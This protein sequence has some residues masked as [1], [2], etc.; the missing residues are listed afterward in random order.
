MGR[1]QTVSD[2]EIIS[3]TSVAIAHHG[4]GRL[5]LADVAAVA[6][7]SPAALVQ[8]FGSKHQLLVAVAREA[9]VGVDAAFAGAV[10][11]PGART[12]ALIDLF[13]RFVA[14]IDSPEVLAN[15]V[16]F[17][18]LDLVDDELRELAQLQ[19]QGV[20]QG[21]RR[22]LDAAVDAGELVATDTRRLSAAVHTTYNGALITWALTG[23]GKLPT[24]VKRE[25]AFALEPYLAV[26]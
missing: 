4:V 6:G 7:I 2:A 25:V 1:P 23:K 12:K 9:R 16:S 21:I 15:H 18:Q 14:S 20:L 11:S 17:L 13:G 26:N 22:L 24:W 19:A 5:T 8:R 10:A 3:A